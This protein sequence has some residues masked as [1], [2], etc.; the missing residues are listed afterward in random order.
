MK[1]EGGK[2]GG[3]SGLEQAYSRLMTMVLSRVVGGDTDT[4][5]TA[6]RS[7]H[8]DMMRRELVPVLVPV[9]VVSGLSR[10]SLK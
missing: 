10:T 9:E 5:R 3:C 7:Q 1:K 6:Q 4:G 2:L 8:V